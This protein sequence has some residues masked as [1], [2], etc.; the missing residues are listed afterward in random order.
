M[1]RQRSE[2][3]R[4]KVVAA[5][6]S[7]QVVSAAVILASRQLFVHRTQEDQSEDEDLSKNREHVS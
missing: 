2:I 3:E 6:R 5:G 7:A 4:T 1:N